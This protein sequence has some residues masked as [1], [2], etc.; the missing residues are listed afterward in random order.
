MKP[1][2]GR[3]STAGPRNSTKF[4]PCDSLAAESP[5]P[6]PARSFGAGKARCRRLI[7]SRP[8]RNSFSDLPLG[9]GAGKWCC[10]AGTCRPGMPGSARAYP[11]PWDQ[12]LPTLR[13]GRHPGRPRKRRKRTCGPRRRR[14]SSPGRPARR[15]GHA[16]TAARRP[17][18]ARARKPGRARARRCEDTR[19]RSFGRAPRRC[20]AEAEPENSR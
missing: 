1:W 9:C 3:G 4:R 10:L 11:P 8:P 17:G 18:C 15:F 16:V 13:V 2:G 12:C 20:G 19:V 5:A 14:D 6:L 7:P